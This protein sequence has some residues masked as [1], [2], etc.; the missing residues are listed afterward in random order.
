MT[1]TPSLPQLVL[2][3]CLALCP[4]RTAA[5]AEQDADSLTTPTNSSSLHY[6]GETLLTVGS[7]AHTPFWLGAGRDGLAAVDGHAPVFRAGLSR[8]TA[9]AY[10]DFKPRWG[11]CVET[12]LGASLLSRF[13][14]TAAFGEAVIGRSHF[15]L[16]LRPH[17]T[18]LNHPTLST[19]SFV[20]GRNAVPPA[21][22]AWS[23]PGWWPAFGRR[24]PIAFSGTFAY[25]M[26]LDGDW[27]RRTVGRQGGRYA[28]GV[29]YHEKSGYVRIG[30]DSSPVTLVAGAEMA[31]Q[32]GGTIHH[33][34]GAAQPMHLPGGLREAFYAL[35]AKGGSDPTDGEGYAN[36][37]GNTVGA[38]RF[39]LNLR[40]RR[41]PWSARLYYDHFFE[42]ESAAF[43]EYGWL[44]GL[45]GL[46]VHLPWRAL[47]TVVVE[48]VRTDYQS[49]PAYH[50]HTP[51]LK[52]QVS[53]I[54]NYYNHGLYPGWQHFGM[55]MGN[56]LFAS[57]LYDRNGTLTFTAN[58]FHA[59]HLGLSGNATPRLAYRL[60]FT[61]LRSW[62]TYAAPFP[63]VQH[64]HSLLAEVRWSL[65][66]R[67]FGRTVGS[68][69]QLTA[70]FAADRGTRLG[71][72]TALQ[73]GLRHI[74]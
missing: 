47:S 22:L 16:G 11:F 65:P 31:T 6:F 60:L 57:P 15:A 66:S 46:E 58:R 42:D 37:S 7:G 55:A 39:A 20:L 26:Q 74:R 13:T 3:F 28:T 27:Q 64:Q 70:A 73:L 14:P 67:F 45:L 72:N 50:D 19:G 69:W 29:R 38:W 12:A 62:G 18:P 48:A 51:Q 52:E 32:F 56:A 25:G 61:T 33:Y 49:G 24:V 4:A 10:P 17:L 59:L 30:T 23:I 53:G 5:A 44:D 40:P 1:H 43:D 9:V 68:G 8:P 35:V 54:D 36:A 63:E 2:L 41:A 71:H 21:T 34:P